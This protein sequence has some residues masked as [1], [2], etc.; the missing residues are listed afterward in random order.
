MAERIDSPEMS[1]SLVSP[2][3][4]MGSAASLASLMTPATPTFRPAKTPM[5]PRTIGNGMMSPKGCG[6]GAMIPLRIAC[7]ARKV[8]RRG[9]LKS[10]APRLE[11]LEERMRRGR[12]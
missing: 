10:A 2:L 4:T 3:N 1:R 12:T 6:S 8:H 7:A 5:T 11:K 9:R